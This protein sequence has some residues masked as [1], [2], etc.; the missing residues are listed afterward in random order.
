MIAA[1]CSTPTPLGFAAGQPPPAGSFFHRA[2]EGIGEAGRRFWT[3]L[4]P[5]S[6]KSL[7]MLVQRAVIHCG[8]PRQREDR[9]ALP[10]LIIVAPPGSDIQTYRVR[11]SRTPQDRFQASERL[12]NRP[13]LPSR[14][15]TATRLARR[16]VEH[17]QPSE[18]PATSQGKIQHSI[19]T[20]QARYETDPALYAPLRGR[21]RLGP[22][23]LPIAVS[24]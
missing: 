6:L 20:R 11:R 17:W 14:S 9:S 2:C 24:P 4:T 5:R 1:A 13:V 16:A 22:T 3:G 12:Q 19:N 10:A 21:L 8:H 15:E 18:S 23:R 7:A